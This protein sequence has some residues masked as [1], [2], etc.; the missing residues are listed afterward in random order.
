GDYKAPLYVVNGIEVTAQEFKKIDKR[1]I[2][3]L[4]TLKDASATALY[5]ARASGGVVIATLKDG[6]GDYVSI[7]DNQLDV[8]FNID[9][10]YDVPTN[11]KEQTVVLKDITVPTTYNYYTVPKMDKEAYLLGEV[12]DWEGLNLL[13]G[14]ANIIFEG[15]YIGKS[16]VNPDLTLDTMNLTLGR[17]KRVIV[18]REKLKDFSSVKFLGANKK[19]I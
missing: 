18:T 13:P 9:L 17:D 8:V 15:T 6:L 7:A 14:E 11:G 12:S 2:K 19:Q 16:L 4:E 5:G 10:P 1:A 3:N